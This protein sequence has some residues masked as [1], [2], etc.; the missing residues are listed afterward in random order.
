MKD[1]GGPAYPTRGGMM[2]YVPDE[3]EESIRKSIEEMDRD[4]DGM[5]LRDYFAGQALIGLI[6]IPESMSSFDADSRDA[7][8]YADEMIKER[9]K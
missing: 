9:N 2:F 1:T 7:Y 5:T 3:H 8:K 6:S 4:F